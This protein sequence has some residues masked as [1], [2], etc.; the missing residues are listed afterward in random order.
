ME[1]VRPRS[2]PRFP[3]RIFFLTWNEQGVGDEAQASVL[4]FSNVRLTTGSCVVQNYKTIAMTW[5]DRVM[6]QANL[7]TGSFCAGHVDTLSSVQRFLPCC[8]RPETYPR[9]VRRHWET[10]G[11]LKNQLELSATAEP[12]GEP[13]CFHRSQ[14]RFLSS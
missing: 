11:W 8:P 3:I 10:T 5:I 4:D 7:V 13:C 14:S 6:N 2:D 9:I 1:A 12:T